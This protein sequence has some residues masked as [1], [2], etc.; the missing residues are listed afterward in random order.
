MGTIAESVYRNTSIGTPTALPKVG[1]ALEN[2]YVF[3][4]SAREIKAMA[5]RGLVKIISESRS[6]EREDAMITDIAFVRIG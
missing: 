5:E 4:S 2:A 3:D 6:S 1:T